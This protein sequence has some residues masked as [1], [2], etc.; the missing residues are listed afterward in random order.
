MIDWLQL[1]SL[2]LLGLA[3]IVTLVI[4]AITFIVPKRSKE[5]KATS[6][7]AIAAGLLSLVSYIVYEFDAS[8]P[9]AAFNCFFQRP[10]P[11][12]VLSCSDASNHV[13]DGYW[14]VYLDNVEV[15]RSSERT[16]LHPVERSG[17]YKVEL[18]LHNK[19]L[20]IDRA[21]FASRVLRLEMKP[22][23][24]MEVRTFPFTA[25]GPN[26]R[27]QEFDV[28][29]NGRIVSAYVQIR[30]ASGPNVSAKILS[31]TE[32]HIV[33]DFN[34]PEADKLSPFGYQVSRPF[35][36]GVLI[37]NVESQT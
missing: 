34:L 5:S 17:S 29:P 23:A 16:F 28:G 1:T 22:A 10:Y 3:V 30:D 21:T 33:V 24:R 37:V 11:P 4:A 35:I 27:A 31:Q 6:K 12:T 18:S 36:E 26:P 32:R 19:F 13:L 8:K 25:I 2:G 14:K 15:Y 9:I 7:L 20:G